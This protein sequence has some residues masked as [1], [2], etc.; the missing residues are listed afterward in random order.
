MFWNKKKQEEHK[1]ILEKL[2]DD[3]RNNFDITE[4]KCNINREEY[5]TLKE[6]DFFNSKYGDVEIYYLPYDN[7]CKFIYNAFVYI[8]EDLEAKDFKHLRKICKF[9]ESQYNNYTALKKELNY[10]GF[11]NTKDI[12]GTI[13][14]NLLKEIHNV[15]L[16][17]KKKR[18]SDLSEEQKTYYKLKF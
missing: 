7:T 18:F 12:S 14:E 6:F 10:I 15:L 9:L 8:K 17:E 16:K 11:I 3:I 5:E 4:W 1:S 13:Y 2:H